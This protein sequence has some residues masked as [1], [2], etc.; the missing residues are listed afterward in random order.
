[1]QPGINRDERYPV[2]SQIWN[3]IFVD[4]TI[5]PAPG[6]CFRCWQSGHGQRRR[7]SGFWA[8]FCFNCGR[9]DR[10]LYLCERYKEAHI[11]FLRDTAITSRRAS[12]HFKGRSNEPL[13][14]IRPSDHSTVDIARILKGQDLAIILRAQDLTCHFRVKNKEYLNPCSSRVGQN[15]IWWD[16]PLNARARNRCR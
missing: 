4:P 1:M 8:H 14:R 5:D 9:R 6:L 3:P 2:I 13:T 10:D 12:E 15:L 7:L 16:I 11:S